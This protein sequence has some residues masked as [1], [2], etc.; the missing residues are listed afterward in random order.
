MEVR[1]KLMEHERVEDAPFVGCLI[2]AISCKR[3]C[4]GCFNQHLKDLPTIKRE[5]EDIIKEVA[6]NP[7]DE[8]I[9][10]AG[11]EWRHQEQEAI[12][13]AY[14]AWVYGLKT[15]LYTGYE[16]PAK[17]ILCGYFDY[18][19]VG[20]Y[21]EELKTDDHYEYGVK[22]ASSNQCIICLTP[23]NEFWRRS[24]YGHKYRSF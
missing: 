11:L 20:S 6:E 12:E 18:V 1:Y 14:W 22:L 17:W 2:S 16:Y 5:A 4:K 3:K 15:M 8:G 10:L 23:V 24:V 13:L 21:K 9:I 19:K 7:F